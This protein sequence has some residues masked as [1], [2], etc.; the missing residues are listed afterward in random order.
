MAEMPVVSEPVL[1]VKLD[2][3][4]NR[5][6]LPGCPEC[7]G[8]EPRVLMRTNFVLYVRCG[9]CRAVWSVWKP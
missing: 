9:A 6:A 8:E 1:M 4:R 5:L 2:R 3:R 7:A